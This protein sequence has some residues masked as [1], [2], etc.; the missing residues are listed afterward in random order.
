MDKIKKVRKTLGIEKQESQ[1][2][3]FQSNARN[4]LGIE[5]AENQTK[6]FYKA[7]KKKLIKFSRGYYNYTKP[8]DNVSDVSETYRK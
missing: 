1:F 6:D 3:E 4:A 7:I 2:K 5:K 8:S